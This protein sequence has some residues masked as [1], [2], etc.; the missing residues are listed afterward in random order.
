MHLEK[1]LL[2]LFVALVLCLALCTESVICAKTRHR[3]RSAY[4]LFPRY[5]RKLR[6]QG[7]SANSFT[8]DIASE[9]EDEGRS[10][11]GRGL[12]KMW[13]GM[14]PQQE[15]NIIIITQPA[16]TA[17]TGT[18]DTTDNGTPTASP[19]TRGTSS[20]FAADLGRDDIAEPNNPLDFQDDLLNAPTLGDN[21]QDE[22]MPPSIVYGRNKKN[23]NVRQRQR[24]RRPAAQYQRKRNQFERQ[25]NNQKTRNRNRLRAEQI[26][27]IIAKKPRPNGNVV[28]L[29][30][31]NGAGGGGGN[32]G[33]SGSSGSS[34]SGSIFN[35]NANERIQSIMNALRRQTPIVYNY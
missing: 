28:S 8:S 19:S 7:R 15:S 21:P 17:G 5:E 27:Q 6:A 34:S 12:M 24:R 16:P 13:K 2:K 26:A 1:I 20:T 31:L 9:A 29:N 32:A 14:F 35:I 3:G 4:R 22:I 10:D 11:E 23:K 33:V 25:R 30:G 18:A